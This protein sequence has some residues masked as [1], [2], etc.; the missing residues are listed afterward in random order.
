MGSQGGEDMAK[1]Q[2]EDQGWGQLEDWVVPHLHADK[3]GGTTGEQDRT[4][5]PGFQRR[6]IKLQNL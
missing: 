5:N 3:P 2:L 4:H 1:W 6:E